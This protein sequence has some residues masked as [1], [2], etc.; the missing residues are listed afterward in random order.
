MKGLPMDTM[1]NERGT[2]LLTVMVM[3]ILL[4]ILG[5]LSLS[6]TSTENSISG[7]YRRE[8]MAFYTAS[9]GIE[10]AMTNAAIYAAIVPSTNESWP[11]S[12]D[13]GVVMVDGV[14]FMP[15]TVDDGNSATT[16]YSVQV[17][18]EY[19]TT[20]ELPRG[21]MTESGEKMSAAYYAATAIGNGPAGS[22]ATVETQF[23][24]L[25]PK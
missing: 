22:Q 3:L 6:T 16:D 10:F 11:S 8:Q 12:S 13:T 9:A 25:V 19:L 4:T 5:L 1:T 17:N 21:S 15:V 2:V 20:G 18:V 14:P 23:A 7:N 24:K